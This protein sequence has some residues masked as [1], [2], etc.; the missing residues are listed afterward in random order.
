MCV[1]VNACAI[2]RKMLII[3]NSMIV[4]IKN[5][6]CFTQIVNCIIWKRW[7]RKIATLSK[8]NQQFWLINYNLWYYEYCA[9]TQ[10]VCLVCMCTCQPVYVHAPTRSARLP[11]AAWPFVMPFPCLHTFDVEIFFVYA[12]QTRM[13]IKTKSIVHFRE[14]YFR[15]VH[16]TWMQHSKCCLFHCYYY[17]CNY[18]QHNLF[19]R[20]C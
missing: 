7:E 8:K 6:C 13:A 17:C 20:C 16:L 3:L 5:N 18:N 14:V 2:D 10:I 19:E 12:A 15:Q 11:I 9:V 4:I 1:Y